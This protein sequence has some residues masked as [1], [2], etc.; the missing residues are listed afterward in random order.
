MSPCVADANK[1]VCF[2]CYYYEPVQGSTGKFRLGCFWPT[3][4]EIE[5]IIIPVTMQLGADGLY[6]V[7]ADHLKIC[8]DNLAG[9]VELD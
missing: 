8:Q 4:V 2:T 1:N 5:M 9:V 3:P 6:T 7:P